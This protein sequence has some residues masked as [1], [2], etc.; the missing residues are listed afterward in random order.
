[1]RWTWLGAL[2]LAAQCA[3][4]GTAH[5]GAL[6]K[7]L[8][9]PSNAPHVKVLPWAGHKSALTLTFDDTSPSDATEALPIVDEEGVK[10]TFF[11]TTANDFSPG[12]DEAWA[13][14]EREGHE[15]GNHTVNHCHS[16]E[17]GKHQCLSAAEEL[18]QCNRYIESRL[19]ARDVYTFA[20]P[21]VDTGTAY[22]TAASSRFLLARA[23]KGGLVGATARPD[24]YAM[25]ARFIDP[26]RGETAK[27]WT[28]WIDESASKSKWL[29][30]V[31]H[32]ILPE[33]WYAG[34]AKT[35]LE[36]IITHAK[37]E[38]DL[39][40]DTFVDVGAYLRAQRMFEA[41]SPV[42]DGKGLIWRWVLPAHFPPGKTLRV[43]IDRG[44]LLQGGVALKADEHDTYAVALDARS[45]TWA[46]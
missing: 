9:R 37:A 23:G 14:A 30:L 28:K 22:K 40:I 33:N 44:T 3:L 25:D 45:L 41:V 46:P 26:V 27:D 35:D 19:G 39:W 1:M 43:H 10:A 32:S 11:V 2:A 31:F 16:A 34:I 4:A 7:T 5:A 12:F 6:R 20:Y 21:Y 8:R 13:R 29:V 24:W 42:P 18:E 17:L 15:L 38:P 36:K